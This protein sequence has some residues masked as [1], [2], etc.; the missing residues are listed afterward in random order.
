MDLSRLAPL[1]AEAGI[2][3]GIGI[4]IGIGL[5]IGIGSGMGLGRTQGMRAGAGGAMEKVKQQL[6]AAISSGEISIVGKDGESMTSESLLQLL[7][8]KFNK[9]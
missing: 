7:E 9:A 3:A 2:G 8:E 4:G 1:L 6:T 5:S